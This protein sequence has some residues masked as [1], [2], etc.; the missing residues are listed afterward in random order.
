MRFARLA[1]RCWWPIHGFILDGAFV[2]IFLL[3]FLL[4]TRGFFTK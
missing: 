1:I 4:K 2:L 3:V